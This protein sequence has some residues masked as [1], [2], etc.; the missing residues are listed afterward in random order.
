MTGSP[1]KPIFPSGPNSDSIL[2][3]S[4]ELRA[5][6]DGKDPYDL[7]RRTGSQYVAADSSTGS[8]HLAVWSRKITFSYPEWQALDGSTLEPISPFTQALLLY[9]FT[10][11]DGSALTGEWIAFSN[12]PDGRFYNQAFQGYTGGELAR[13]F[14]SDREAF[15]SA[16]QNAGGRL[17]ADSPGDASF[18]F[19]ALP[20]IPLLLIFWQGDEE[21]PSSYQVLF[22]ASAPHYLPTDGFAILGSTVTNRLIAKQYR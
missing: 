13:H 10:T 7:A 11:A 21:F 19:Q 5:L 12:L 4:A 17:M 9:Y 8:F 15:I 1:R 6:L 18:Y 16:A 3:K 2:R 22:D 14:K 20:R